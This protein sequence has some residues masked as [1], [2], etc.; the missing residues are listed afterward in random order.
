[1]YLI[2]ES[3]YNL[4]QKFDYFNK[5]FFDGSLPTIPLFFVKLSGSAAGAFTYPH[6]K[7]EI[8]DSYLSESEL[9]LDHI[10]IHEMIHFYNHINKLDIGSQHHGKAFKAKVD[11]INKKS[12]NKYKLTNTHLSMSIDNEDEEKT[13]Y[14]SI[15]LYTSSLSLQSLSSCIQF[16]TKDNFNST[17]TSKIVDEYKGKAD[18]KFIYIV[19][20][21]INNNFVSEKWIGKDLNYIK[22]TFFTDAKS[23]YF[24]KLMKQSKQYKIIGKYNWSTEQFI[25]EVA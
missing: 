2:R 18:V 11:E 16:F 13:I 15:P 1:M 12:N 3:S 9:T 8:S 22:S 23:A 6:Y 14:A 20:V 4:Q 25:K 19:E 5:E 7:I 24:F 17:Y 10:F 21:T